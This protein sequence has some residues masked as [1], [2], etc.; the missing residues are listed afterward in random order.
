MAL[1]LFADIKN[2]GPESVEDLLVR[3]FI[4][5]RAVAQQM[6]NFGPNERQRIQFPVSA[7]TTGWNWGSIQLEDDPLLPDNER[8][9]T[10]RI[11]QQLQVL[12]VSHQTIDSD[13]LKLALTSLETSDP[14]IHIKTAK[15]GDDWVGSLSEYNVIIFSNYPYL[16]TGEVNRLKTFLDE[17]GGMMI[18]PGST[19]DLRR[20]NSEWIQPQAQFSLGNVVGRRGDSGG[21]FSLR[22]VDLNHPLF[23]GMFE[24]GKEN[25]RSPH[26]YRSI[27]LIGDS[28]SRIL[29]LNNGAP[30]LVEHGI[31]KGR[32]FLWTSGFT[33]PWSDFSMTTLFAPLLNRSVT[34]LASSGS[35]SQND[36]YVGEPIM[37]PLPPGFG[38]EQ[39]NVEG[40]QDLSILLLPEHQGQRRF[41]HLKETMIPGIYR[42]Y[43]GNELVAM[44]AVNSDP[45]ESDLMPLNRKALEDLLPGIPLITASNKESL[46]KRVTEMRWGKEIRWELV[47]LALI[48]LLAEMALVR[49]SKK[50]IVKESSRDSRKEALSIR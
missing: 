16:T 14:W 41:L 42:F 36:V 9:F 22:Q 18:I 30:L 25:I 12:L 8:F 50:Y 20:W 21:Y 43:R 45:L 17:G 24:K 33:D 4:N 11:P 38:E 49:V 47:L 15:F 6:I 32:L 28:F 37:I 44:A 46:E 2:N 40:P 34:Y 26:F 13:R 1:T 10:Y 31:G 48:V 19:M 5:D 23:D 3:V 27:V 7:S 39:Y 35:G 29:S